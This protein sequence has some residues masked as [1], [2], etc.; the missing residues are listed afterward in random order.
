MPEFS[1]SRVD[2]FL[3][4]WM[5]WELRLDPLARDPSGS[6]AA[7]TLAQEFILGTDEIGLSYPVPA[8]VTTGRPVSYTGTVVLS[9]KPFVSLTEQ[10]S[11][12]L[13]E[14]AG[15]QA[16]TELSNAR[17]DLA[18]RKV[19]SQVLHTFSSA[20]TLRTTIPQIPVEN[21]V[22]SPDPITRQIASAPGSLLDVDLGPAPAPLVNVNV[23][24][25]MRSSA[26]SRPASSA[27]SWAPSRPPTSSSTRLASA[28]MPR[29]R[30]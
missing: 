4:I 13:S 22:T 19:M 10:I 1:A 2:P 23:A 18:G 14:Y 9:K 6:Y 17:D 21:L 7:G 27:T 30:C 28:R 16:D 29:C 8:T 20:Q 12:Y 24:R 15:D 26:R 25:L 11:L 3:P 5:T